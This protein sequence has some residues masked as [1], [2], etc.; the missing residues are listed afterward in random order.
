MWVDVGRLRANTVPLYIKDLSMHRFWYARRILEAIPIDTEGPLYNWRMRLFLLF[1]PSIVA[2]GLCCL[3][4]EW[5]FT[6]RKQY[7]RVVEIRAG[8]LNK[9]QGQRFYIPFTPRLPGYLAMSR[10]IFW[11]RQWQPTPVFLPGE[12]QGWGSLVGCHL[13]GGTELDTTEATQ[14]Q[15]QQQRYF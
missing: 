6:P 2:F 4:S 3:C 1:I 8:V 12:S 14:Q 9:E 10:D 11:R 13:W 5:Q 7:R 15:Q